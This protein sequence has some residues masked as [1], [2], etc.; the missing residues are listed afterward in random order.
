MPKSQLASE[1]GHP[2]VLSPPADASNAMRL[3]Y[4]RLAAAVL[5]KSIQDVRRERDAVAL[6]AL[7]WL[8]LDETPRWT[9]QLLD[10]E[11]ESPALLFSRGL[12]NVPVRQPGR[13]KGKKLTGTER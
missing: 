13:K 3:P 6:E 5:Y 11:A 2:L 12:D 8:C 10:F 1:I 9:L 4:L 7:M